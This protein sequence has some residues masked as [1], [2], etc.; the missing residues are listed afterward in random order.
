MKTLFAISC[1]S[2]ARANEEWLQMP[3]G[4]Y[5]HSSCIHH[6]NEPFHLERVENGSKITSQDGVVTELPPCPYSTRGGDESNKLIRPSSY[7]SDWSVYAQYATPTNTELTFMTS[8]WNVPPAPQSHGPF[9]LSSVY[10]FNG[11]EDGGGHHGKCC[12]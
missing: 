6:H 5:Y 1:I 12:S 8:Q 2:A 3:N 4:L 7:Y 11:L 10:L 9:G